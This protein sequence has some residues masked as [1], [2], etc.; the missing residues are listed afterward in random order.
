MRV[1]KKVEEPRIFEKVE[2]ITCNKCGKI[3]TGEDAMYADIT[4]IRI[5]FGYGSIYDT[6]VMEFDL[7]D[8]CIDEIV[9]SFKIPVKVIGMYG[10]DSCDPFMGDEAE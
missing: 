2:S 3:C 10:I 1:L 5:A 8:S 9:K 6:D 7:C 4:D